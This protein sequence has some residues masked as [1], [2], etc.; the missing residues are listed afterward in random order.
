MVVYFL[1]AL[2]PSIILH[3]VSHGYVALLFG[4]TTARDAHRL[5]LNPLR[6]IDPFGSVILPV[7]LSFSGL[8]P[9]GWAKPVPV[10]VSRL[11]HPR[12]D[13]LWV[14]LA[15][16]ATNIVLSFVGWVLCELTLNSQNGWIF[17]FG[18]AFGLVNLALA[19]FN[20]IPLP[21]LDGS[22]MIER[23]IPNRHMARYYHLR[24]R[25]LVITMVFVLIDY[26]TTHLI[27]HFEQ[28]LQNWW[29]SLLF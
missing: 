26:Q 7:I 5:T 11:R 16:P 27:F 6:H 24:Q 3:E 1:I 14:S 23:F 18:I 19:A 4:D 20:L 21:P 8:P 28:W 9:I 10:N 22:A 15:G 2:V 12:S 25:A 17:Q 13:S 29:I